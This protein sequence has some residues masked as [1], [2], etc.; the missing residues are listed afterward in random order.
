MVGGWYDP[1][2]KAKGPK[3][4][5]TRHNIK[6]VTPQMVAYAALQ[7]CLALHCTPVLTR[8]LQT[9]VGLSSMR[10]WANADGTFNLIH[11]YHLIVKTLADAKDEWVAETMGWWQRYRFPL[12]ASH[13]CVLS[14]AT[15]P[16]QSLWRWHQSCWTT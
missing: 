1:A 14:Q 10:Q 15:T 9:Y 4:F 2:K 5:V 16:Q 12:T 11:F 7:V 6:E 3:D 8:V 13:P